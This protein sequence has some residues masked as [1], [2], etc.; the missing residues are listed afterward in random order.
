[1]ALRSLAA[2]AGAWD[3]RSWSWTTRAASLRRLSTI[4][5]AELWA[6]QMAAMHALPGTA[7]RNDCLALLQVFSRG[8]AW[9]TASGRYYARIWNVIFSSLDDAEDAV[10]LEWM[11]AHLR[12]E[13]VGHLLLSDGSSLTATDRSANAEADRLAKAAARSVRVP[14][15]VRRR[16]DSAC[17]C[18]RQLA[19]WIGQATAAASSLLG[20]GILRDSKPGPRPPRGTGATRPRRDVRQRTAEEGG[21]LL[22][23]C[24]S[25][26]RCVVCRKS[27]TSWDDIA[28]GLCMGPAEERWASRARTGA[29]EDTLRCNAHRIRVTGDVI[30]CNRC[31]RTRPRADAASPRLAVV[32]LLTPLRRRASPLYGAAITQSPDV[33][34]TLSQ[35]LCPERWWACPRTGQQLRS[36]LLLRQARLGGLLL[37]SEYV[38]VARLLVRGHEWILQL[39]LL[40]LIPLIWASRIPVR[41]PL[42]LLARRLLA[43]AS[44]LR[45]SPESHV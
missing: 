3:G 42:L 12:A 25:G 2:Y 45:A 26:W 24:G 33:S 19:K 34:S 9:A 8:R 22:E 15:G 29:A 38:L 28:P 6:L 16:I 10:D 18:A 14:A 17:E 39:L 31:G 11:P 7:Y 43:A 1:M 13:D 21:H 20:G 27:S 44:F 36:R 41:G 4:H 37:R 30:W 23:R 40:D 32:G 35:R 5:G